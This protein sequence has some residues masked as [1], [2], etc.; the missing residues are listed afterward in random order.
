PPDD[1]RVT[2]VAGLGRTC[3]VGSYKPNTFGLYD[4][5]GNVDE[6]CSDLHDESYYEHSPQD[7]P[8]GPTSGEDHVIRGGSW[9]GQGEDCR[10]AVR[11]GYDT[12]F[13]FDQVGLRVVMTF[14]RR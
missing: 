5:H 9:G 8:R 11:I 6:W 1:P 10:A 7:D 12:D 14:L 2:R 4:M 3:P 13:E